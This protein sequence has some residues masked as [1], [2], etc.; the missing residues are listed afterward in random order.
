MHAP[1]G[2][3]A[4]RGGGGNNSRGAFHDQKLPRTWSKVGGD[5]RASE[6][7]RQQVGDGDDDERGPQPSTFTA[8]TYNILADSAV[9][10]HRYLYDCPDHIIEWKRRCELVVSDILQAEPDIVALQ[11]MQTEH[12]QDV[13]QPLLA[14]GFEGARERER[15][16]VCVCVCE[17]YEEMLKCMLLC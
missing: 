4:T 8:L 16:C 1:R 13:A 5:G 6:P 9:G 12:F 15:E 14:K 10:A 3:G 2:R 7:K 17:E 11:E